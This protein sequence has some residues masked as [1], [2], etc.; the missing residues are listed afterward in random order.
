V[1]AIVAVA[2]LAVPFITGTGEVWLRPADDF[3]AYLVPWHY[4]LADRWRFPLLDIPAMGYP[5]GGSVLFN[6]ALPLGAL[7]TKVLYSL[8]GFRVN[9]FGW[10]T[11]LTYVLQGAMTARLMAAVGVPRI[12]PSVAAATLAVCCLPFLVRMF[13]TALASHFLII[14]ALALYFES[15]RRGRLKALELYWLWGLA[16]LVNGYLLVMVAVLGGA[17]VLELRR[18]GTL[19]PRDVGALALGALGVLAIGIVEGYGVI[20]TSPG[21]LRSP[22]LGLYSWNPITLFVPSR[23]FWG[24]PR[25]VRDATGGQYEG[26]GYIGLGAILL[27]GAWV[28]TRPRAVRQALRG[29]GILAVTLGLLAAWAASN[30]VYIGGTLVAAY[31]LPWWLEHFGGYVR[32][33]GRFVW[34]LAYALVILPVAALYRSGRSAAVVSL[35]LI[36]L[37]LQVTEILPSLRFH[38]SSTARPAWPDLIDSPRVAAWLEGHHRLWQ[39]PSWACGG[40]AGPPRIWKGRETNRELQLELL[41][42]R[43]GTPTNSVYTSRIVKD[44]ALEAEWGRTPTLEDG[45]LYVLGRDAARASP[46]LSSLAASGSCRDLGWATFCSRGWSPA[47]IRPA[48][49]APTT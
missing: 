12:W 37:G 13:H 45:V 15:V 31:E 16:I 41:V 44:C 11:A 39:Y 28:V 7:V 27:L 17:T 10:W 34:P 2:S 23:S 32:A 20:F 1:G 48:D 26:D 29:H 21:S 36:A 8:S 6:D 5:E 24:W 42:A 30:R 49:L 22:G 9:P 25:V 46:G 14:W 38:R 47:A 33:T 43:L 19:R 18:R 35:T 4:F 40:L 3:N